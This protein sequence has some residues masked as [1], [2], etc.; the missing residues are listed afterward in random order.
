MKFPVFSLLAGNLAFSETSSQLTSPSSG[1]SA[2]NS[3][4]WRPPQVISNGEFMPAPQGELQKK[5]AARLKE[6]AGVF[7]RP[8]VS[9]RPETR[10]RAITP[11]VQRRG[12]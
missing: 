4:R 12:A 6:R 11:L 9:G 3:N 8:C 2:A 1:E 10:G 7:T 5:F